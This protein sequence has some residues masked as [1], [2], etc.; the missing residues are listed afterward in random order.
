ME[1]ASLFNNPALMGLIGVLGGA[2]I[3]FWGVIHSENVK[4]EALK[5]EQEFKGRE[6]REAVYKHFLEAIKRLENLMVEFHEE[7][8][9]EKKKKFLGELDEMRMDFPLILAEV[10]LYANGEISTKCRNLFFTRHNV[11]RSPQKFQKDYDQL[12]DAMKESLK[13]N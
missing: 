8:N 10:D 12:V 13:A 5:R 4:L 7:E 1:L 3:S 9:E 11:Y 6:K 2:L